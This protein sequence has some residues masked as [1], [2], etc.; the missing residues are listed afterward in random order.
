[1]AGKT[2]FRGEREY[3]DKATGEVFPA[4]LIARSVEGDAGFDKI[5]LGTILELV[6]EVGNAKMR[7]LLWLLQNRD[8]KNIVRATKDEIAEATGTSRTSV[9]RLLSALKSANVISEVR[10]SVW[11]LNPDVIW[12]GASHTRMSVMIQYRDERAEAQRDLFAAPDAPDDFPANVH[13]IKAA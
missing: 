9:F 6:D 7:V 2:L 5:W 10:R 3:I 8:A 4:Q 13:P 11:R 1:M 12:K